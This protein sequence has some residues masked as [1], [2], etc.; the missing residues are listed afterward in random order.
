MA[1]YKLG[2]VNSHSNK[3]VLHIDG[4]TKIR[5]SY[6]IEMISSQLKEKALQYYKTKPILQVALTEIATFNI[7]DK[8]FY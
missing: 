5:K 4:I 7:C 3:L 8:T 6:L 2:L 1:N